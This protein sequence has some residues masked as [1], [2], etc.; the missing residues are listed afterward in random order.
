M[1]KK[2]GEPSFWTQSSFIKELDHELRSPLN[3]ILGIASLCRELVPDEALIKGHLESLKEVSYDLLGRIDDLI[4][5]LKLCAGPLEAE[6]QRFCLDDVLEEALMAGISHSEGLS[7]A[8]SLD[9]E[10][11]VPS[12]L[13]ALEQAFR[14]ACKRIFD[15]IFRYFAEA[16]IDIKLAIDDSSASGKL[17]TL[18]I[19]SSR[20]HIV[21]EGEGENPYLPF[22]RFSLSGSPETIDCGLGLA[23]AGAAIEGAGRRI[24]VFNKDRDGFVISFSL[25]LESLITTEESPVQIEGGT[26]PKVCVFEKCNFQGVLNCR[27]LSSLGCEAVFVPD[28]LSL[29]GVLDRYAPDFL[30][31]NWDMVAGREQLP[32]EGP[33]GKPE[34]SIKGAGL[35]LI[36]TST[37]AIEAVSMQET[38]GNY[39]DAEICFLTSPLKYEVLYEAV[40]SILGV[41]GQRPGNG[42]ENIKTSLEGLSVLIVEDNEINQAVA[43]ELLRKKNIKAVVAANGRSVLKAAK[44]R[45]FDLILM[46]ICLPDSDGFSLTRRIRAEGANVG[47][48]IIAMT[49]STSNMERCLDAG[50]NDFLSKPV[51]PEVLYRMISRWAG[52]DILSSTKM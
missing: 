19:T 39:K 44:K 38:A 41:S 4:L 12:R 37:P 20:G 26:R 43:L 51:D 40:S 25:P 35:P 42:S 31:M 23:I 45:R 17:L 15:F 10:A 27:R 6:A 47:T 34:I 50:M 3:T 24:K 7:P 52:K 29:E 30:V 36:V 28:E 14:I 5:L 48:P 18:S 1:N 21:A 11:G 46:D 33:L 2:S 22:A 16:G 9:I 32:F 8:L 13:V 49:A